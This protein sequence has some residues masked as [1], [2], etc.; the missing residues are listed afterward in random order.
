[1]IHHMAL[2]GH[3]RV[4]AM[5]S[6]VAGPIIALSLTLMAS[7]VGAW[8]DEGHQIVALI[9]QHFLGSVASVRRRSSMDPN[10]IEAI[11]VWNQ[12]GASEAVQQ[13]FVERGFDVTPMRAGLLIAGP[14]ARF[15]TVL[16]VDLTDLEPPIQLPIPHDI[17][18][19][20]AS[21]SIPK[22][23]RYHLPQRR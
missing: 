13:W 8:G 11:L 1:M 6:R 23:P 15:E 22:V 4:M 12:Q 3:W 17:S 21:F 7:Q 5:S 16:A 14:K 9:A 2:H 18:A 19:H 10:Y 20:V